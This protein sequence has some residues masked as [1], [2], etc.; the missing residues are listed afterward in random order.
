VK[1]LPRDATKGT[2]SLRDKFRFSRAFFIPHIL[3]IKMAKEEGDIIMGEGK[4]MPAISSWPQQPGQKDPK[5]RSNFAQKFAGVVKQRPIPNAIK[6]KRSNFRLRK[7]IVPKAPLCVLNEMVGQPNQVQYTF[8]DTDP[9]AMAQA[10]AHIRPGM[11][12]MELFTAQCTLEGEVFAGTGPSKQIAKNIA[13]EHAIQHFFMKKFEESKA[14]E[15]KDPETGEPLK[16]NQMEDETP[17]AQLASLALFKLFNDW[18]AQGYQVPLELWKAPES[19]TAAAAA[20]AA[21]GAAAAGAGAEEAEKRPQQPA[22]K[23]PDNPT[24]RHPVQLLNELR[25]G[26]SYALVSETGTPPNMMFTFGT[27]ID[28]QAFTGE[29]KNKKDAKKKCAENV[30]KVIYG[31]V[32][33]EP[34]VQMKTE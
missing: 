3:L 18:Q 2:H 13:A 20:A 29:G 14:K 11:P 21:G 15:Q 16:P 27:E 25:G 22:K 23:M 28:G 33:P 26:V 31:V 9:M 30:L 19:A 12:K 10:N 5:N 8:V 17:W 34:E 1:L 24:D 7:M 32:Y 4:T 6:K